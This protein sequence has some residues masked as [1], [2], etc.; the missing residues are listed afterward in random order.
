MTKTFFQI[1]LNEV[2]KSRVEI[3]CE[4]GPWCLH[5]LKPPPSLQ[6]WDLS[7]TSTISPTIARFISIP[8]GNTG[9][10]I[11]IPDKCIDTGPLLHYIQFLHC[12]LEQSR[13]HAIVVSNVLIYLSFL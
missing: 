8:P 7:P 13:S 4:I 11:Q 12:F 1:V 10:N 2:L 9:Q 3:E 5:I 6:L